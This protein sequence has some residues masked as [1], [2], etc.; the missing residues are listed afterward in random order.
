[1]HRST[2]PIKFEV[3]SSWWLTIIYLFIHLGAMVVLFFLALPLPI[4]GAMLGLCVLSL[5]FCLYRQAWRLSKQSIVKFWYTGE[6]HWNLQDR[7]GQELSAR[8][9]G[10]SICTL[11]FVL[12]NFSIKSRWRS[13]SVIILPDAMQPDDLRR[14]RVLLN[15]SRVA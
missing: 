7:Q 6:R 12:L 5:V 4:Q 9:K 15:T 3:K 2:I 11:H 13:C 1:M 14:L 8:L 10:D